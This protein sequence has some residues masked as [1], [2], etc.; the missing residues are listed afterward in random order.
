MTQGPSEQIV[1]DPDPI[2][3]VVME[4]GEEMLLVTGGGPP[5]LPG[6]RGLKGEKGEKGDKGDQG[7]RGYGI[8][9][10]GELADAGALPTPPADPSDAYI[11]GGELYVWDSSSWV[12][13]GQFVGP[14]G[15]DG[16]QG[17]QGVS[18]YLVQDTVNGYPFRPAAD[19]PVIFVGPDEPGTVPGEAMIDGDVWVSTFIGEDPGVSLHDLSDVD[20]TVKTPEPG[21][22][23]YQGNDGYWVPGLTAVYVLESGA[24]LPTDIPVGVLVVETEYRAGFVDFTG[25]GALSSSTVPGLTGSAEFA[26]GGEL[27]VTDTHFIPTASFSGEGVLA[28]DGVASPGFSDTGAFSGDGELTAVGAPSF[29]AAATLSGS[30]D[31]TVTGSVV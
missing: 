25:G 5:G 29:S 18:G 12:N 28:V 30:G 2:T 14:E 17:I 22:V 7:D 23:L 16:P 11:I 8:A 4:D 1:F 15:P 10:R 3:T 21:N 31:L 9:I 27:V 26:G 6:P 24:P 13:V 20:M 19:G